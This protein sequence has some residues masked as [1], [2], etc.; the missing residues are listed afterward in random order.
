MRPGSHENFDNKAQ[1][2]VKVFVENKK[3]DSPAYFDTKTKS[4]IIREFKDF[5]KR[6]YGDSILQELSQSGQLDVE[7][8]QIANR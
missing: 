6:R 5:V 7:F 8:N 3:K 1:D 4:N 2:I